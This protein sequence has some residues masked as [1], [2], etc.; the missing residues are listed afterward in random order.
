MKKT[1]LMLTASLLITGGIVTG[2]NTPA[3]KVEKAQQEVDEANNKLDKVTDEYQADIAKYRLEATERIAANEKSI[4]EFNARIDDQ[5]KV[6]KADYTI[7]I[8]ELEKKNTDMKKKMD[9]YKEDGKDKWEK[10]KLE[11]NHDLEEL[12][13]AFKDLTVKNVQ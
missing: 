12:G 4:A 10:F 7:K 6:A 8:A 2:C 5:K 13:K 9:D 1:I 3:E 11:F